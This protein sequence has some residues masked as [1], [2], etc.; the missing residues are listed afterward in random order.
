M[1]T[2]G[3]GS[4]HV[5]TLE[6]TQLNLKNHESAMFMS[7]TVLEAREN[8]SAVAPRVP[9]ELWQQLIADVRT[10]AEGTVRPSTES[11]QSLVNTVKSATADG[12][13][14]NRERLAITA[15]A[16]AVLASANV[17]VAELQAVAND[18]RAIRTIF[19]G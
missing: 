15:A 9:V 11:V 16:Q 12:I 10:L 4:L 8:P 5:A 17:P 3:R 6:P 18:L 7:L 14:T 19:V 13:V 1:L 2:V